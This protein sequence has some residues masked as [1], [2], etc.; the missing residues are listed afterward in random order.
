MTLAEI[1]KKVTANAKKLVTD[2][3]HKAMKKA[4]GK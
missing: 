2:E 1:R 4:K 3:L